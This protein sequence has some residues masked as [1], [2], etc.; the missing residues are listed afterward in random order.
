MVFF[1]TM[2]LS[3][4]FKNIV[5]PTPPPPLKLF[6]IKLLSNPFACTIQRNLLVTLMKGMT[7]TNK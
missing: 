1:N 5:F 3:Q 2:V 7:K 6:L 4:N